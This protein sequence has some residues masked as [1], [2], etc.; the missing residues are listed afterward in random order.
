MTLQHF[1]HQMKEFRLPLFTE[2]LFIYNN[3]IIIMLTLAKLVSRKL[4]TG[5]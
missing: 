4:M 5:F 2:L 1:S 3:I